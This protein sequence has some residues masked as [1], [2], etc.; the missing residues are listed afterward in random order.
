[1]N[2]NLMWRFLDNFVIFVRFSFR[3]R[4]MFIEFVEMI[5]RRNKKLFLMGFLY[6]YLNVFVSFN[7]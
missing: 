4:F 7:I 2:F 5:N 6:T 3:S 1:M